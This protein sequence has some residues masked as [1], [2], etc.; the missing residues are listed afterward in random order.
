MYKQDE[1]NHNKKG[2]K[3]KEFL[4]NLGVSEVCTT[5]VTIIV[6][7]MTYAV[8]CC[9]L[10]IHVYSQPVSDLA[11]ETEN[12]NVINDQRVC[13]FSSTVVVQPG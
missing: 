2:A 1:E 12:S 6:L 3:T 11:P 5:I 8:R 7:S 4:N 10:T 9:S 13:R